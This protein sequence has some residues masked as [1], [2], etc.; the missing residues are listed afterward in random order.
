MIVSI[1][2]FEM[3]RYAKNF[4][5][6]I[7]FNIFLGKIIRS[8][9]IPEVKYFEPLINL[10]SNGVIYNSDYYMIIKLHSFLFSYA[11]F[12]SVVFIK[13]CNESDYFHFGI[14]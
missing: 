7:L 3:Y 14:L 11:F 6:N 1:F 2:G 5:I 12:Y 9:E 10:L 13:C 4:M 8:S